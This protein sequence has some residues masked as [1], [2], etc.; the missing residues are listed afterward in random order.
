MNKKIENII[1]KI[2]VV[3]RKFIYMFPV[4][5]RK[6]WNLIKR[7][8]QKASIKAGSY[9]RKLFRRE[10]SKLETQELFLKKVANLTSSGIVHIKNPTLRNLTDAVYH[11]ENYVCILV[12]NR[13]NFF[14]FTELRKWFDK[15]GDKKGE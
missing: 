10:M 4:F 15:Y 14:E 3:W 11:T 8:F 1:I 13:E 6:L 12:V 5:L 2:R 7:P 9:F